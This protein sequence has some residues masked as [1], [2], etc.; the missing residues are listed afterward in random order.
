MLNTIYAFAE[1]ER[2]V[3][4]EK[5][6]KKE[7]AHTLS[8]HCLSTSKMCM[9]VLCVCIYMYCIYN[10]MRPSLFALFLTL[11][12]NFPTLT[13]ILSIV[14]GWDEFPLHISFSFCTQRN[15]LMQVYNLPG[16]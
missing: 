2:K 9:Y 8:F 14:L 6:R 12:I 10:F 1:R 4:K 7:P 15:I 16:F 11:E 5:D 13:M 3:E